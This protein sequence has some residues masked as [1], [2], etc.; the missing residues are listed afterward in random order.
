MPTLPYVGRAPDSDATIVPK[1]YA[2]ATNTSLA[3]NS[4]YVNAQIASVVST[5]TN[6]SYVDSEDA[7][8]AHK[9]AVTTADNSYVAATA[10]NAANGVAG[11]DVNGNL[12]SSQFPTS[13]V[14]TDRVTQCYSVASPSGGQGLFGGVLSSVTGAVGTILL[15]GSHTVGTSSIRE[16]KLASIPI[17]DPGFPWRPLPFAWVQGSSASGG[18]PASRQVGNGN[19]GLLAV[20][21]PAGVSD[22][23]YGAGICTGSSVTDTYP[24]LPYA[25]ANQSPTTVPAISGSLELDLF[26][27]C[28]SGTSYTFYAANLVYLVMV[29][30]AL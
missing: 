30:P 3:V 17:P 25:A 7:L 16:Y 23:V 11:L 19:Y 29:V 20:M 2:D 28:W 10:L 1:S 12:I 18:V 24:V 9:S 22:Q 15:S 4:S 5:L 14:V 6:Q 27:S 26:G 13:G 21:P 8:R